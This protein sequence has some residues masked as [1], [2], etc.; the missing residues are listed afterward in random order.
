MTGHNSCSHH[1][2]KEEEKIV[3]LAFDK[4]VKPFV[5]KETALSASGT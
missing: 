2:N 3:N 4:S 1:E 5:R